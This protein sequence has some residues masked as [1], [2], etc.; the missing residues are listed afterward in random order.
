[1]QLSY[2]VFTSYTANVPL[3]QPTSLSVWV[4]GNGAWEIHSSVG[5]REAEGGW[6]LVWVL[7]HNI[8]VAHAG[9]RTCLIEELVGIYSIM[10]CYYF[11]CVHLDTFSLPLEVVDGDQKQEKFWDLF[12]QL[13][14]KLKSLNLLHFFT[15]HA[16]TEI[17]HKKVIRNVIS[18]IFILRHCSPDYF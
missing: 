11:W 15:D 12:T 14:T 18:L 6:W 3:Y 10:Q 9:S 5:R 17:A 2:W 13:T 4:G 1:M 16:I 8:R 7:G